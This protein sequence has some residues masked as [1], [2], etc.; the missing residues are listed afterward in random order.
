MAYQRNKIRLDA[1]KFPYAPQVLHD[2][3]RAPQR[4]ISGAQQSHGAPL[5]VLDD[6]RFCGMVTAERLLDIPQ[7]YWHERTASDA[8]MP[9][10]LLKPVEPT[11]PLSQLIP[12]LM[13]KTDTT[14]LPGVV[15]RQFAMHDRCWRFVFPTARNPLQ[16]VVLYL[17]ARLVLYGKVSSKPRTNLDIYVRRNLR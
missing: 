16:S 11:T 13:A 14:L 5:V 1:F 3:Q 2:R 15:E 7:G 4:T 10:S 17:M 12:R 6:G 9:S 8:L